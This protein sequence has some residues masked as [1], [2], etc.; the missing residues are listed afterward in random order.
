MKSTDRMYF[1]P[2]YY[3]RPQATKSIKNTRRVERTLK[4]IQFLNKGKTI[5]QIAKHLEIHEKSVNRYFN[6]LL[7]FGIKVEKAYTRKE[8]LYKVTNLKE[9]FKIE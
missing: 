6:L 3:P 7:Q 8:N 4:L 1:E 9:F 5:K 2:K